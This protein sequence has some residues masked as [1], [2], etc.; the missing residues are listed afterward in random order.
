MEEIWATVCRL[1]FDHSIRHNKQEPDES[2]P[3][4]AFRT[5]L[6]LPQERSEHLRTEAICSL[7]GSTRCAPRW[8]AAAESCCLPLPSRKLFCTQ[9]CPSVHPQGYNTALSYKSFCR[10]E[11]WFICRMFWVLRR[12]YHQGKKKTATVTQTKA[13]VENKKMFSPFW[14]TIFDKSIWTW[15]QL[16]QSSRANTS[17]RLRDSVIILIPKCAWTGVNNRILLNT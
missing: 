17:A 7:V 4:T 8:G 6:R 15:L 11:K 5:S 9:A 13:L 14:W 2:L 10:S 16:G 1:A 3:V 12:S